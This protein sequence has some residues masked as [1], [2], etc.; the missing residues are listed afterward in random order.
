[1]YASIMTFKT[2]PGKRAEA[3]KVADQSFAASKVM[4]GFKNSVYLGD[5]EKN[6]Y[7]ALYIWETKE[8]M[9][10]AYNMIMPKMQEALKPLAIEPPIRNV[11]EVYEPKP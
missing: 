9:E 4:K 8:D 10:A 5:N 2:A 6:E 3:E 7:V 11:Y 1:M